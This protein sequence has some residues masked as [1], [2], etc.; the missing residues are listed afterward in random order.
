M[1]LCFWDPRGR[2]RQVGGRTLCYSLYSNLLSFFYFWIP[3]GCLEDPDSP[4]FNAAQQR[5][6]LVV[7]A[8]LHHALFGNVVQSWA[9]VRALASGPA[10]APF[11]T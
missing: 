4:R 10:H 2:G 7:V 6:P 8:A 3:E 5:A 9:L 1:C 11:S